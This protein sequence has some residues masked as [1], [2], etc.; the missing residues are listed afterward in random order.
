MKYIGTDALKICFLCR[1]FFN[2]KDTKIT[3][4]DLKTFVSF[5]SFVLKPFWFW[6]VQVRV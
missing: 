4:E 3:K 5:V 2:T 6:L 1:D